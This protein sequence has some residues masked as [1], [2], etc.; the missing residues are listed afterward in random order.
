MPDKRLAR[1]PL[2]PELF[3]ALVEEGRQLRKAVEARA[4]PTR[5]ITDED[6]KR[7]SK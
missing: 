7:R 6:W 1:K 4:A 3:Q 2:T 5:H